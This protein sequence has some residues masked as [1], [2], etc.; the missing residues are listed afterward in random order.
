M[1]DIA[2]VL[3]AA[4]WRLGLNGFFFALCAALSAGLLLAI[5]LRITQQVVHF[6][7]DWITVAIWTAVGC[8]V[9]AI[10]CAI[11]FRPRPKQVALTVDQGANLREALST[12]LCIADQQDPWSRATVESAARSARGVRL[13]SAVPF[14]GPR[15]WPVPIALG[16]AF[17]VVYLALPSLDLF[18]NKESVAQAKERELAIV[19]VNQQT[20]EI[21]E[22]LDQMTQK[23]GLEPEP[24]PPT[25]TGRPEDRDPEAI[26]R[27]AIKELT[28]LSDKLQQIKQS[29]QAMKL[30]AVKNTLAQIKPPGEQTSDLSKSLA[31]GNFQQAKQDL[32]Q[33][34]NKLQEGNLSDSEK[35]AVADQ[36]ENLAE[37]IKKAAANQE[38]LSKKLEE[39]GINP[40]AAKDPQA[41]K[42]A[43]ENAQNL[44]QE[45]KEQ[46]ES[47]VKSAEKASE[48][49]SSVAEAMNQMAQ[50]CQNPGQSNEGQQSNSGE[51]QS[52]EQGE[53]GE[54][55]EG[56]QAA[57]ESMSGQ[58]SELEQIAMEMELADAALSECQ[59]GMQSLGEGQGQCEGMGEGMSYAQGD[60]GE[61][62]GQYSEGDIVSQGNG[63]GGPGRGRGGQMSE[64]AAGFDMTKKID[65]KNQTNKGPVVASRLVEGEAILNESTAEFSTAVAVAEGEVAEEI[66]SNVIP[67]DRHEAVK[68]YFGRL[69]E[70]AAK[71]DA[72]K[73]PPAPAKPTEAAPDAK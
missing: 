16:L 21:K 39:M 35:Q 20:L 58:L 12:A 41:L 53:Q 38:S 71:K 2:R 27:S 48:S 55:G 6:P 24:E 64:S 32:E 44:S 8:F 56:M 14:Q 72:A 57:A 36:L 67:K 43:I 13:S 62:T 30:E 70:D 54:Q 26:R 50:Q 18:S 15:F 23:L 51:Q 42:E 40:S 60:G 47:L 52:G 1:N 5:A 45:Q 9:S 3:R 25:P 59:S 31:D 17:A 49:L 65:N 46:L 11:V 33:M 10:A 4:S 69:R 29:E 61:G 34:L 68:K 66:S 19:Q 63:Q 73:K 22:K 7:I 37:Q 28:K